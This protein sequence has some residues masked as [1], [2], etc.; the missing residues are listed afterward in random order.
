M[1]R[2]SMSDINVELVEAIESGVP[3][4]GLENIL[5]AYGFP[6]AV[7]D[8][9]IDETVKRVRDTAALDAWMDANMQE[10]Y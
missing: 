7:I 2:I 10:D 1:K 5:K 3:Y 4:E 9:I 6:V 8:S